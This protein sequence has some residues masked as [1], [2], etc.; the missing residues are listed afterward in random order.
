[1]TEQTET[2]MEKYSSL[3]GWEKRGPAGP[4]RIIWWTSGA[5]PVG[6]LQDRHTDGFALALVDDGSPA[7]GTNQYLTYPTVREAQ[8][9]A[10]SL[11][12][13]EGRKT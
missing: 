8:E 11:S 6:V 2:S 13:S 1:M 4:D 7:G 10:R 3:P 9:A 5:C 12:A